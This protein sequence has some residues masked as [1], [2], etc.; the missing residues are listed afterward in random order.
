MRKIEVAA[1][2]TAVFLE[3]HICFLCSGIDG[4]LNMSDV[5]ACDK[6]SF[7]ILSQSRDFLLSSHILP[8]YANSF[9]IFH[10]NLTVW[11]PYLL[12]IHFSCVSRKTL[13]LK[14]ES[15][16]SSGRFCILQS[17]VNTNDCQFYSR[18]LSIIC[19]E[20]TWSILYEQNLAEFRWCGGFFILIFVYV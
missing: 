20:C 10:G 18:I 15:K 4:L 13:K 19:V 11:Y 12:S 5:A 9:I 2:L 1:C 6:I 14:P 16:M 8:A 3:N 7:K 17:S